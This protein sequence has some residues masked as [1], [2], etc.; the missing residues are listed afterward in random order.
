[1]EFRSILLDFE[2]D[3]CYEFEMINNKVIRGKVIERVLLADGSIFSLG[4][5]R[6]SNGSTIEVPWCAIMT[7]SRNP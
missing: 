5:L 7:I 3:E 4:V 1:M 2:P 6:E